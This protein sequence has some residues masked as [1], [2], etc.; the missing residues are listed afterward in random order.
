MLFGRNFLSYGPES[1]NESLDGEKPLGIAHRDNFAPMSTKNPLFIGETVGTDPTLTLTSTDTSSSA[2][3]DDSG[4]GFRMTE[5]EDY[6]DYTTAVLKVQSSVADV[7]VT[8]EQ[9]QKEVLRELEKNKRVNLGM[10]KVQEQ[11]LQEH[12]AE[13]DLNVE[14]HSEVMTAHAKANE[15]QQRGHDEILGNQA[16]LAKTLESVLEGQKEL[17]AKL[18]SSE[19]KVLEGQKELK[20]QVQSSEDIVLEGQ[21]DGQ[22]EIKAQVKS[23]ESSLLQAAVDTLM[24]F[25]EHLEKK[26]AKKGIRSLWG[27]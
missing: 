27:K 20:A 22:K 1:E 7:R 23:S 10:K 16:Q 24:P 26:A 14:R 25:R 2:S 17:K 5:E 9:H 8:Q 4:Y 18:E 3:F 13:A 21:K 6:S 11:A 15:K 12:R 19:D